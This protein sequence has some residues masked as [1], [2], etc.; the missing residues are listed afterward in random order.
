ME[1]RLKEAMTSGVLVEFHDSTGRFVGQAIFL[2]WRGQPVPAVG[3]LIGCTAET[4]HWP[5]RRKLVGQVRGRHF[6]MQKT[7]L[8]DPS[9]WVRL[10]VEVEPELTPKP[11]ATLPRSVR[12]SNN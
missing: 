5:R 12:F 10:R 9:V 8:G 2:D 4:V 6:D 3:D 11:C 1:T 7:E